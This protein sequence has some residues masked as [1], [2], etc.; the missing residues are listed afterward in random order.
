MISYTC[1]CL[2]LVRVLVSETLEYL[3]LSVIVIGATCS[4]GSFLARQ[5]VDAAADSLFR[6]HVSYRGFFPSDNGLQFSCG[7]A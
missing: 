3:V 4:E 5:L 6:S 2:V 1:I 7:G